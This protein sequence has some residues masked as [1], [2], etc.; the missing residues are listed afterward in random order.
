MMKLVKLKM[1]FFFKDLKDCAQTTQAAKN[2]LSNRQEYLLRYQNASSE[3]KSVEDKRS[4]KGHGRTTA[5][6]GELEET[7]NK[8]LKEEQ[9]FNLLSASARKEISEYHLDRKESTRIAMQKLVNINLESAQKAV[10]LW[11]EFLVDLQDE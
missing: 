3:E 5:V 11:K 9:N 1:K 10:N 4:T 2:L 6:A 8:K 7:K